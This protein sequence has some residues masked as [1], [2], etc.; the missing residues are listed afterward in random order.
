MTA[1]KSEISAYVI[2]NIMYDVRSTRERVSEVD[3][4]GE[5]F[6]SSVKR[7]WAEGIKKLSQIRSQIVATAERTMQGMLGGGG[8]LIP[9]PVRAAKYRRH[10]GQGRSRD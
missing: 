4:M 1:R 7:R 2:D 6:P 3:L 8:T 10:P 9:I 5:R